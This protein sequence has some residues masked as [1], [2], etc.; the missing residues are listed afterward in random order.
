M[1][2]TYSMRLMF[3]MY[4]LSIYSDTSSAH[5]RLH[6]SMHCLLLWWIFDTQIAGTSAAGG[7]VF[8]AMVSCNGCP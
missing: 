5:V 1:Y 3:T 6:W 4:G 8:L 2:C 7:Y